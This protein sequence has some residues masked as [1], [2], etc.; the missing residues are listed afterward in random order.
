[1]LATRRGQALI[2]LAVF[3][4]VALAAL[5]F[6]IRMGMK[7]GQDQE[8]R[9]AAFRRALAAGYADNA[10]A[11]AYGPTSGTGDAVGTLYHYIADRQMPNPNDGFALLPRARSEASAFVEW[12][13]R[14]TMAYRGPGDSG[15]QTEMKYVV[16]A[17]STEQEFGVSDFP[18]DLLFS[19]PTPIGPI[20]V[21]VNAFE[22]ISRESTTTNSSGASI[23]QAASALTSGTTTCSTTTINTL[24]GDTISGC[25]SSG[26]SLDW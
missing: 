16:R 4:A 1:M 17:N 8:I 11:T 9:M 24:A 5:G 18:H 15:R 14:F 6:L 13:D 10:Q 2:E 20:T 26:T 23:D 12:G 21:A 7:M 3:G 22:G 25:V 19:G